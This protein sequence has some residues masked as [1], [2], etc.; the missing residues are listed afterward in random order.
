MQRGTR[1][2]WIRFRK[3]DQMQGFIGFP[4]KGRLTK[5]PSQF[6]TELLPQIDNLAELK[7]ALY[8]FWRLQ[9]QEGQLTFLRKDEILADAEFMDGFGM[10]EDQ[11]E[12]A[13]SDALERAS[14][15]GTLLHVQVKNGA[16]ID[17]L[18]FINTPKGRA[19]VEGIE[20][21]KWSPILDA[22]VPLEVLVERPNIYRLYEQNIGAL[23]PLIADHLN[24]IEQSYPQGWV[25]EAIDIAVKHNK[26]KLAYVEAILKRWQSEGRAGDKQFVRDDQR[27]SQSSAWDEIES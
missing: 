7:V 2:I 9:Q 20:A 10:Q 19:A 15:R 21:G 24:E 11:R 1:L 25:E 8:A 12:M 17:D 5:I 16:G 27:F 18:Y 26:Q 4:S 22:T 13:L 3:I 14:M 6:F 23:T